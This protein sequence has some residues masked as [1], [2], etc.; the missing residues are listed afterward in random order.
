MARRVYFAFDYR[1]V[2]QVNQIRRAGEFLG[3]ARAGFADASQWEELK[4]KDDAVIKKAID[5]TLVGTS[6]TVV[7]VGERTANRRWVKYEISASKAR[8]NGLVAV[9]LPGTSGHPAPAGMTVKRWDASRFGDWVDAAAV[10]AG[11]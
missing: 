9:Y 7:C 4:K 6:V 5:D 1:D 3:M 2:F 8:G 11:K 10:A